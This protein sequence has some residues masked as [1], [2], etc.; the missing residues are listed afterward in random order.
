MTHND[1]LLAFVDQVEGVWIR[2][3]VAPVAR[4]R[5]VLELSLIH[6]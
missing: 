2:L 3:G 5:L 1:Q 6:I 4:R